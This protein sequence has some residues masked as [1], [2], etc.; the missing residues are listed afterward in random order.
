MCDLTLMMY[1]TFSPKIGICGL[2]IYDLQLYFDLYFDVLLPKHLI[3]CRPADQYDLRLYFDPNFCTLTRFSLHLIYCPPLTR[4]RN[5]G[6]SEQ[7]PMATSFLLHLVKVLPN[8]N[9]FLCDAGLPSAPPPIPCI[10]SH[11][12]K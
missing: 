11:F 4:K 2:T 1:L 9:S 6:G 5:M 10:T 3:Y 12:Y 8:E 7:P